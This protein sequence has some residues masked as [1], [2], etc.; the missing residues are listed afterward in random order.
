M[1]GLAYTTKPKM[2]GTKIWYIFLD[3][4]HVCGFSG[5]FRAQDNSTAI[6]VPLEWTGSFFEA[7]MDFSRS[8]SLCSSSFALSSRGNEIGSAADAE[9]PS[10][11]CSMTGI[12]PLINGCAIE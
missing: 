6:F 5:S 2:V 9:G 12:L 8:L 7:E 3:A 10:K 11:L 4:D 1:A